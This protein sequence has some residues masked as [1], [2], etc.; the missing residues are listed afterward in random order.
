MSR[1]AILGRIRAALRTPS[2]ADDEKLDSAIPM[3]PESLSEQ[4]VIA[5]FI[6]RV[7][8]YKAIVYEVT[9]SAISDQIQKICSERRITSVVVPAGIPDEWLGDDL[10][11]LRDSPPLTPRELDQVNS[12]LTTCALGIA[13]TGTIV[14]DG[15]AGQGRRALSLVP[16]THV[17]VIC[18]DQIVADV[19]QAF[20]LLGK[21]PSR[22]MT[23]ISGPS[24]TSDIELNRVEGVHGPRSLN[25]LVVSS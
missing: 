9:S 2:T 22:P 5:R 20:A 17:C 7:R 13:E 14:L 8:D 6:E 11:I 10:T 16:D 4:E 3:V 18:T 12:V 19:P 1:D 23:F 21:N 24:A 25:V 15:D